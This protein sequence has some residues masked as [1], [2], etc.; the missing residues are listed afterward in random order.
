MDMEMKKNLA[1]MIAIELQGA[2]FPSARET[3]I[4][5]AADTIDWLDSHGFLTDPTAKKDA[6][7][8]KECFNCGWKRET[9]LGGPSCGWLASGEVKINQ[10]CTS[11][12]RTH[13]KP[14]GFTTAKE[15]LAWRVA[16]EEK[17][18]ICSLFPWSDP[19]AEG[20]LDRAEWDGIRMRRI[21][22][23][24]SWNADHGLEIPREW[25]DEFNEL[26]RR[27]RG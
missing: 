13:W 12:D 18:R 14:K 19:T 21:K 22:Q 3:F 2:A 11:P 24:I 17:I 27:V 10:K 15:A 5:R 25:T 16:E 26:L 1:T 20:L 7:P 6:S 9:P 23:A 8:K 4:N